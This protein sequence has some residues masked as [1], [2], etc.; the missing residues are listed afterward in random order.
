MKA[1]RGV[2]R[3][4]RAVM[5]LAFTLRCMLAD[6][7]M[8]KDGTRLEGIVSIETDTKIVLKQGGGTKVIRRD[9]IS[10]ITKSPRAESSP[11]DAMP[12][13]EGPSAV[14]TEKFSVFKPMK[15]DGDPASSKVVRVYSTIVAPDLVKPWT[16][17]APRMQT[18]SGTFFGHGEVLTTAEAVTYATEVQIQVGQSGDKLPASVTGVD[19]ELDV[20][21]VQIKDPPEQ[22]RL[23]GGISQ[24]GYLP[25]AKAAV[26]VYGYPTD[27]SNVSVTEAAIEHVDFAPPGSRY[28][29]MHIWLNTAFNAG[30]SGGPVLSSY[31]RFLGMACRSSSGTQSVS[32]VVPHEE[33]DGFIGRITA[34]CGTTPKLR[35]SQRFLPLANPA[36][37]SF[38]G[39]APSVHGMLVAKAEGPPDRN[40]FMDWD[41]VTDIG[42][43][44]VDDEGFVTL[45]Y[46]LRLSYGYAIQAAMTT[47][48]SFTRMENGQKQTLGTVTE[49]S[50]AAKLGVVPFKVIRKGREIDVQVPLTSSEPTVIRDLGTAYPAYFVFGPIVFSSAT[51]QLLS[52]IDQIPGLPAMLSLRGSPLIS[53][54]ADGQAFE[55]EEL[56]VISSPFF[57]HKLAEG[58]GD[59]SLSVVKS[60]NGIVIRNLLHLVEVLRDSRDEFIDIELGDQHAESLIFSRAEMIAATESILSDN[61]VRSQG[62]ADTMAVW[63]GVSAGFFKSGGSSF[64]SPA[65]LVTKAVPK[66]APT[67][68]PLN[69]VL[70]IPRRLR[71]LRPGSMEPEVLLTLGLSEY[72]ISSIQSGSPERLGQVWFVRPHYLLYLY[73]NTKIQPPTLIEGELTD[74]GSKKL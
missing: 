27:A 7:V 41:V 17:L 44:S 6:T 46:G 53:R 35:I 23:D 8:L 15:T 5:V 39:I 4:S 73:F 71:S 70:G 55:G 65:L 56:V 64:G 12:S 43:A 10:S 51:K 69:I 9:D 59:P 62:S 26:T 32:F 63:K 36:L 49:Q 34:N 16:R 38:L 48:T 13:G 18:C 3:I 60:V 57:P 11:S 28:V 33:T 67:E 74:D 66:D 29:G 19:P 50:T 52:L 30:V 68:V 42:D 25:Q 21:L 2:G 54:R 20:A 14:K 45:G 37:G 72:R 61:D 22:I 24:E 58:Y 47:S 31:K 1:M 40:P